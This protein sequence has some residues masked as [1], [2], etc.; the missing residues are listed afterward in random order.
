MQYSISNLNAFILI[1]TVGY[2]LHSYVYKNIEINKGHDDINNLKD[3]DNSPIQLIDQLK[4]YY[5][6]NP[7]LALSLSIT[8]FSFVGV[9]PLIGFFAKQMVLSA[10]LDNGYIFM[11]LVAILTSVISAVYYLAIV[12][13]IFFDKPNYKLN[14]VL[15]NLNLNA[16][17]T[18]DDV[19]IKKINFKTH[20]IVISSSLTLIISVLTLIILLFIII[21][22]EWLNMVNILSIILFNI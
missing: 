2:T 5:Y 8:L 17:I 20:N 14:P 13:Q 22:Q 6:I 3:L 1:I 4:G 11:V 10:A 15:N 9:P 19:T 18:D 16:I 12:K 21:P 7:F